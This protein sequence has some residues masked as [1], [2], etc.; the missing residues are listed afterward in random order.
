MI[1]MIWV[2]S[3][4]W[5]IALKGEYV[6]KCKSCIFVWCIVGLSLI[7]SSCASRQA[8]IESLIIQLGNEDAYIASKAVD[9]LVKIG[10]PAVPELIK[11]LSV[12]NKG[13][14]FSF[15]VKVLSDIGDPAVQALIEALKN[16]DVDVRRGAVWA[17]REDNR[18]AEPAIPALIK[19]LEDQKV[20]IRSSAVLALGN[21]G[22]PAVPA[23]IIALHNE[24]PMIRAN[25]ASS[26]KTIGTPEAKKTVEK[27]EVEEREKNK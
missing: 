4:F 21:I 26:L 13:N 2:V 19:A 18:L 25:A 3:V 17:L 1:V 15:V 23:L 9:K 12:P 27:W 24:D 20:D 11:A 5:Q 6:M 22:K 8:K 14:R 10:S 7:M 16:R